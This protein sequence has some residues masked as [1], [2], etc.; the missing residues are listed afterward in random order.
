M[1]M[2]P[3]NG[4]L[5][6]LYGAVVGAVLVAGRIV[7][8]ENDQLGGS[9]FVSQRAF[10]QL[11]KVRT[12][13]GGS[14]FQWIRV[15]RRQTVDLVTFKM[16]TGWEHLVA[17][18]KLAAPRPFTPAE[19]RVP[20]KSIQDYLET[21]KRTV[22]SLNVRH[23]WWDETCPMF[24]LW[25]IGGALAGG[26]WPLVRWLSTRHSQTAEPKSLATGSRPDDQSAAA[27]RE[28]S[29][30]DQ[31]RLA[32]LE[33][34]MVAGLAP[35]NEEAFSPAVRAVAEPAPVRSLYGEKVAAPQPMPAKAREYAGEYYP[36]AKKGPH[37]FTLIEVLITIGIIVILVA[38]L[39]PVISRAREHA[40]QSQCASNLRQI[41]AG[42]EIYNQIYRA[43]PLVATNAGVNA[44]M[45]DVKLVGVMRCPDDEPGTLS[46]A[47]NPAYAGLPK[48]QGNAA[49]PM[50]FE[51]GAGHS[52]QYNTVYFDGHVDARPRGMP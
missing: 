2:R 48:A 1:T 8:R 38:I 40:K 6:W 29:D 19:T 27:G 32:A 30:A 36:V 50:A 15:S 5:W 7:A 51:T 11:L 25:T 3:N 22:P 17:G 18:D 9:G 33:A 12:V 35:A 23:A 10:E 41:G 45:A 13:E 43:L 46:Y 39:I 47:M 16:C 14:Y 24:L 49:D 26:L 21:V 52:G 37:G 28:L 42:M 44:A 31:S 20:M 34:E 4:A